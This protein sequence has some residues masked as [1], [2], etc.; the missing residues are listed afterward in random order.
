MDHT[1]TANL[2]RFNL[3]WRPWL[4][5]WPLQ[6]AHVGVRTQYDAPNHQVAVHGNVLH[7]K[8][9]SNDRRGRRVEEQVPATTSS[10]RRVSARPLTD[11]GFSSSNKATCPSILISKESR[12][13]MPACSSILFFA[14]F[15]HP[16]VRYVTLAFTFPEESHFVIRFDLGVAAEAELLAK[17]S[18]PREGRREAC[19]VRHTGGCSV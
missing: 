2:S 19:M 6:R 16:G 10:R 1:S 5:L 7:K 18:S 8:R 4:P 3:P 9:P 17:S 14:I 15:L 12:A 11:Q 13:H